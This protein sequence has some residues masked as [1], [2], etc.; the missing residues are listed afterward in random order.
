M[1]L[2]HIEGGL[3]QHLGDGLVGGIDEETDLGDAGRHGAAELGRPRAIDRAWARRIEDEAQMPG[4][5]LHRR[6]H[7]IGAAQPADLDLDRHHT[8]ARGRQLESRRNRME[9]RVTSSAR[10]PAESTAFMNTRA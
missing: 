7:G 2:Q 9:L 3:G 5:I 8:L 6:R 10:K 4:A 1:E